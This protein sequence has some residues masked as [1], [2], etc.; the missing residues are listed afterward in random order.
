MGGEGGGGLAV[1]A[2][3]DEQVRQAE[4]GGAVARGRTCAPFCTQSQGAVAGV[5]FLGVDRAQSI[6]KSAP[7]SIVPC[8]P[9]W[10]QAL[11]AAAAREYVVAAALACVARQGERQREARAEYERALKVAA[12]AAREAEAAA[13]HRAEVVRQLA[14]A[15]AEAEVQVQVEF[16]KGETVMC[17]MSLQ[18]PVAALY[19]AVY[20]HGGVA[21]GQWALWFCG[22]R[23]DEGAGATLASCGIERDSIIEIRFRVPGG[24]PSGGG[25]A[26]GSSGD[27]AAGG[28]TVLPGY[29]AC[30]FAFKV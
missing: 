16:K 26:A 28:E 2:G 9:S 25:G 3:A 23:L 30:Y 20:A 12:E 22:K 11:E 7:P 21:R 6:Y 8:K 27:G 19:V 14:V 4:G 13:L 18:R 17:S 15:E 24:A 5:R 10:L 1:E 29:D